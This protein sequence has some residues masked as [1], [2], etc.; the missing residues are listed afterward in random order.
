MKFLRWERCPEHGPPAAPTGAGDSNFYSRGSGCSTHCRMSLSEFKTVLPLG[1]AATPSLPYKHH[2]SAPGP[3]LSVPCQ[4][5]SKLSTMTKQITMAKR[6]IPGRQHILKICQ[7]LHEVC[8]PFALYFTWKTLS[9]DSGKGVA[10][11]RDVFKQLCRKQWCKM[12]LSN[13]SFFRHPVSDE[14]VSSNVSHPKSTS[15][16]SCSAVVGVMLQVPT[17][18]TC[19]RQRRVALGRCLTPSGTRWLAWYL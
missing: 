16:A 13:R 11:G 18:P 15:H 8:P 6:G 9:C 10:G 4:W 17:H 7:G 2:S 3:I 5:Q 19:L 1:K 12:G 14:G